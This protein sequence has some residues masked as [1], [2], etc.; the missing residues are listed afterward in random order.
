M[1]MILKLIYISNSMFFF[2]YLYRSIDL[3][4]NSAIG[5]YSN[6]LLDDKTVSDSAKATYIAELSGW[7]LF[8][9]INLACSFWHTVSLTRERVSYRS[10]GGLTAMRQ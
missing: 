6:D 2:Y 4:F 5:G 10:S 7:A 9:V 3:H 1:L 8:L